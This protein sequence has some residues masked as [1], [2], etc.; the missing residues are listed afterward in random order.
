MTRFF[1]YL[2][3]AT[4]SLA[5][6]NWVFA[7]TLFGEDLPGPIA[8]F[9]ADPDMLILGLVLMAGGLGLALFPILIKAKPI[10]VEQ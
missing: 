6:F 7:K 8:R 10:D 5:V 4:G 2:C 3:A 1:T 9:A